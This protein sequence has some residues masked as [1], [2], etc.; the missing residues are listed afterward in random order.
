[1][2]RCSVVLALAVMMLHAPATAQTLTAA[3][4]GR[5]EFETA[6]F[7]GFPAYLAGTVQARPRIHGTLVLPQA[8]PDMRL[9]GVILMHG[10]AGIRGAERSAASRLVKLGYA[11]FTVDRAT[12]RGINLETQRLRISYASQ[13][14]DA[15]YAL[16]VLASHPRVDP[17]RIGILGFSQGGQLAL[18]SANAPLQRA[19]LPEGPTFAAHV[20]VYPDCW[21]SMHGEGTFT[22][23]PVLLL[24]GGKDDSTPAQRCLDMTMLHQATNT[25]SSITTVVYPNAPHNWD[26]LDL[27][28]PTHLKTQGSSMGC[29]AFSMTGSSGAVFVIEKAAVRPMTWAEVG[30]I[31]GVCVKAGATAG[32]DRA[33]AEESAAAVTAFLARTLTS[34]R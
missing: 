22:G 19:L 14:A 34:S 27:P 16:K 9:P 8:A 31:A 6:D 11:T 33:T 24:L 25:N 12:G 21:F 29:P 32:L 15:F 13:L 5:L 10:G 20:G 18:L 2:R 1:M 4:A 7:T 28:Q 17:L 30:G 26:N 3:S 23:S